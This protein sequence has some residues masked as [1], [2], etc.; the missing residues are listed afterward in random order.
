MHES[1][2]FSHLNFDLNADPNIGIVNVP[3]S[4]LDKL[5]VIHNSVKVV[6]T[7]VSSLFTAESFLLH[8]MSAFTRDLNGLFSGTY[9][10]TD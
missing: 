8:V 4:R 6:P 5:G 1:I 9:E 2:L 3:D 10:S 7:S